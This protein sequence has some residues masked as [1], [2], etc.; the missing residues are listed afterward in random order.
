VY[1]TNDSKENITSSFRVE[2]L[3]KQEAGGATSQKII[4][5]LFFTFY[6]NLSKAE[7]EYFST[8]TSTD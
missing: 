3:N 2:E 6:G 4:T 5:L 1:I 8:K 7:T